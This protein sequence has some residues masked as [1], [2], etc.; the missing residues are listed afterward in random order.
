M[1]NIDNSRR[2]PLQENI[3]LKM[4]RNYLENGI[5]LRKD[6]EVYLI[7]KLKKR[8][9]CEAIPS[10]LDFIFA[11]FILGIWN[12]LLEFVEWNHSNGLNAKEIMNK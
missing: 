12:D 5:N 4:K 3:W 2:F 7:H 9:L 10:L 8:L 1:S 6:F 11:F